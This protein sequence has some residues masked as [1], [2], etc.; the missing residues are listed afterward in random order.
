MFFFR[1][2][3]FFHKGRNLRYMKLFFLKKIL[4]TDIFLENNGETLGIP[5]TGSN[6][7]LENINV[8][9]GE[10]GTEEY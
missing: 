9:K 1:A 6:T 4:S 8:V 10:T 2:L 3:Y 5:R 7:L